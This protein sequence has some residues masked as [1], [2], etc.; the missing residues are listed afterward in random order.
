MQGRRAVPAA[1]AL[2]VALGVGAWLATHARP[3]DSG[4]TA[5][6]GLW[7][8]VKV[9]AS[10]VRVALAATNATADFGLQQGTRLVH[11]RILDELDLRV[12]IES[13]QEIALAALPR[14]CLVGPYSAPDDAGLTD[15]CWGEPDLGA[16]VGAQLPRDATGRPLFPAGEVAVTAALRR[17][18]VRC[19][20]PPGAW[21]LEVTGAS[22]V[23]G[24]ATAETSTVVQLAV[25][26]AT[27]GPLALLKQTRYCGLA[28]VVFE[29]QGEPPIQ[30]P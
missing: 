11:V 5:A 3:P 12:S 7:S 24:E 4:G 8:S 18:D 10:I 28:T 1:I 25:S 30:S 17:G 26:P 19:D 14:F 22:M 23:A 29:D 21:V 6:S 13:Q 9:T 20:Y 27:A 2:L 15:R 16:L